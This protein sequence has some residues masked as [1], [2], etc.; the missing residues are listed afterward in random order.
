M[1]T[2]EGV[3]RS[4]GNGVVLTWHNAI[5]E[6]SDGR[7][8][9][10]VGPVAGS[11]AAGSGRSVAGNRAAGGVSGPP[12]YALKPSRIES[13]AVENIYAVVVLVDA[14]EAGKVTLAQ[15]TDY[16]AMVSLSQLD[17]TADIGAINSILQLFAP[18]RPG[19]LPTTLTEW[20]ARERCHEWFVSTRRLPA[21]S[22]CRRSRTRHPRR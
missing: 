1:K 11:G 9:T 19:V 2:R 6:P 18:R 17:L 22:S 12:C 4:N 13:S 21:G 3:S 10:C 5:M 15:L 7:P 20:D 16:L 14:R 8:P